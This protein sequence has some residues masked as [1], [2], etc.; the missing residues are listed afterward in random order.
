MVTSDVLKPRAAPQ[1][2][3][4]PPTSACPLLRGPLRGPRCLS[5]WLLRGDEFTAAYVADGSLA[6]SRLANLSAGLRSLEL[7]RRAA[8]I[9]ENPGSASSCRSPPAAFDRSIEVAASRRNCATF[10]L[11]AIL[12]AASL[13]V[14][15]SQVID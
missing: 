1:S 7:D 4:L 3:C 8:D 10:D 2:P 6:A 14:I 11:P 15:T 9:R 13:I 12:P 5:D